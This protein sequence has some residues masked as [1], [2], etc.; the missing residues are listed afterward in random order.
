[1]TVRLVMLRVHPADA[2]AWNTGQPFTYVWLT[3]PGSP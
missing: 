1:L 3:P 2:A